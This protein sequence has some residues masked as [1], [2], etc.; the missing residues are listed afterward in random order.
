V[1][2]TPV[3]TVPILAT[4]W[5]QECRQA[6]SVK[7][8]F[9]ATQHHEGEPQEVVASAECLAED[10]SIGHDHRWNTFPHNPKEKVHSRQKAG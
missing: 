6:L 2:K 8:T 3:K 10:V 9:E 4:H 1:V 5:Y 7:T